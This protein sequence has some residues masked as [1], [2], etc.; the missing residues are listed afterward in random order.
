MTKSRYKYAFSIL[1]VTLFC[2]TRYIH[3]LVYRP[4]Y[5]SGTQLSWLVASCKFENIDCS[6]E[7]VEPA[8]KIWILNLIMKPESALW[9]AISLAD[10]ELWWWV[11]RRAFRAG[12]A[13]FNAKRTQKAISF[14]GTQGG[15]TQAAWRKRQG[16]KYEAW[17][18]RNGNLFVKSFVRFSW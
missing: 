12:T 9:Q 11:A 14:E 13:P 8:A 5:S 4:L 15:Q 10:N 3:W 16:A 6:K 2:K 7:S 18:K 1:K 17:P